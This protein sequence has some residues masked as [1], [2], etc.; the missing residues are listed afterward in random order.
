M[1]SDIGLTIKTPL[2]DGTFY[3]R[4]LE[5]TEYVSR[6]FEFRLQLFSAK[7]DVNFTKLL[8]QPVSVEITAGDGEVIRSFAGVASRFGQTN[9]EGR[10]AVYEMVMV[11]W[12]WLLSRNACCDIHNETTTLDI[13]K[14]VLKR[15]TP[16]AETLLVSSGWADRLYCVQYRESDLDFVSR[17]IEED[18]FY[19]FFE[20]SGE[21]HKMVVADGAQ[22]AETV[23]EVRYGAGGGGDEAT[24]VTDFTKVQE[25]TTGAYE[26]IDFEYSDPKL[27]EPIESVPSSV[28]LGS[29]SNETKW[30]DFPA[31]FGKMT[32]GDTGKLR[33]RVKTRMAE[34][35]S[36]AVLF[37]GK[38]KV[39]EIA[40]GHGIKLSEAY[41]EDF[42]GDYLV[43]QVRHTLTACGGLEAGEG[44]EFA[45]DNEFECVPDGIRYVPPRRTP[46]PKIRGVH[47]AVVKEAIDGTA[48]VRVAFPWCK[49]KLSCWIRVAQTWAGGGWGAQFHPRVGHEVIIDFFEGDPDLPLIVGR[50]YNGENEG[51]YADKHSLGGFKSRSMEGGPDNFNE[52]R[53]E[54]AKGNEELFFHAEK[55]HIIEVE[56]DES[57]EI[58]ENR[59]EKVGKKV[60]IDIGGDRSES[61]KGARSLSVGGDKSETVTGDKSNTVKKGHM[62]T[63]TENMQVDVTKDL[64]VAAKGAATLTAGAALTVSA[65]QAT[66]I[67]SKGACTIEVK[68]AATLAIKKEWDAKAKK[69]QVEA[70]DELVIKVGKATI[71]MKSNGD[72]TLD[73]NALELKGSGEVKIKGAK[74]G[75]Q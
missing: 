73:G 47:T 61:V 10:Y 42:D 22:T 25:F 32:A 8:G 19:W 72:I 52:I 46:K 48:R 43:T 40:A 75:V 7:T 35:D 11:P 3:V 27:G 20:P 6:A 30:Y 18:G 24:R 38:S 74:S 60:T 57:K 15:A 58:G 65:G 69:I 49:D 36:R 39:Y 44:G 53:F 68:E 71:T 56:K 41:R 64:I 70:E 14:A 13:V 21:G 31:E 54:D 66:T 28:D 23:H 9:F 37:R 5:G 2:E 29:T 55:D 4:R 12:I 50:V 34:E 16:D 26:M 45:Y 33:E 59:S 63:I 1:A 62:E 51:P 67:S 17:L